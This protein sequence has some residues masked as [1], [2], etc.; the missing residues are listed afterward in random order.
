MPITKQLKSQI[1]K[2][3]ALTNVDTGS[4]EVQ[5]AILSKRI[6]LLQEHL[7]SHKKDNHSRRG[8]LQLVNKM[9]RQLHYLKKKDETRYQSLIDKLDMNK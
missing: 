2:A 7:K 6:A 1:I 8:L 4:P 5:I 9:R 3:N